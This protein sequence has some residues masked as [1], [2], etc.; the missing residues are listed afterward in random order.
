MFDILWYVVCIY[1]TSLE[2][3]ICVLL[4]LC[5]TSWFHWLFT[6]RGWL[7]GPWAHA[8]QRPEK[9]RFFPSDHSFSCLKICVQQVLFFVHSLGLLIISHK[10]LARWALQWEGSYPRATRMCES[11]TCS[12]KLAPIL[13]MSPVL[14]NQIHF[15]IQKGSVWTLPLC[16]YSPIEFPGRFRSDHVPFTEATISISKCLHFFTSWLQHVLQ[17]SFECRETSNVRGDGTRNQGSGCFSWICLQVGVETWCLEAL[18]S[19]S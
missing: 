8:L 14:I 7:P 18:A 15:E 17:S 2:P 4:T 1:H 5:L 11:S 9:G 16:K 6:P 12:N 3:E 19:W 13:Q 10:D